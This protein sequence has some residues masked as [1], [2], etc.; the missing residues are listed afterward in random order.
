MTY[1]SQFPGAKYT[2][3]LGRFHDVMLMPVVG[4]D[5]IFT[6]Q[7]RDAMFVP[8]VIIKGPDQS[9]VYCIQRQL[10]ENIYEFRYQ[11]ETTGE[12]EVI[13]LILINLL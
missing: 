12:Y 7:T 4:V 5:T 6:V 9:L 1:L 2:P 10:S 3:P 11:P 13:V 8:E